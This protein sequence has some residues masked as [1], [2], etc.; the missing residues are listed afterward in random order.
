M[1]F[2]PFRIVAT[3]FMPD[4]LKVRPVAKE[5]QKEAHYIVSGIQGSEQ[6]AELQRQIKRVF[7]HPAIWV[8]SG[9]II[10]VVGINM[11]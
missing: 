9:V 2:T 5:D 1:S 8:A 7:L 11:E 3:M 4:D 10:C 6:Q